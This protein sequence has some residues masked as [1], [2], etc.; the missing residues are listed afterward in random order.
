MKHFFKNDTI[1]NI[2]DKSVSGGEV[3]AYKDPLFNQEISPL[4]MQFFPVYSYFKVI[5]FKLRVMEYFNESHLLTEK[6]IIAICPVIINDNTGT[7][8]D[9]AWIYYPELRNK[10]AKINVDY[11]HEIPIE[12][13]EDLF[14]F[15]VYEDIIYASD[16]TNSEL[17]RHDKN[18]DIHDPVT[19]AFSNTRKKLLL[20]TF[21]SFFM[22]CVI[23]KSYQNQ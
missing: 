12:N 17:I 18:V 21:H 11:D 23:E 19:L 10:L 4:D 7:P 13:L 3:K 2:I 6:R 20:K 15:N 22:S 1:F 9:F 16:R 14:H 5:G 8:I